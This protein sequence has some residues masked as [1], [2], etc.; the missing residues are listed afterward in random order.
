MY[1]HVLHI[2][3]SPT[4]YERQQPKAMAILFRMIN[5]REVI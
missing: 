2:N 5:F 4:G 3:F 1:N